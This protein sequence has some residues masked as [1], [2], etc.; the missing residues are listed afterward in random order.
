MFDGASVVWLD[1]PGDESE[2]VRREKFAM[3]GWVRSR[4]VLVHA[5]R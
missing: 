4:L 1:S 2:L 5:Y 3:R